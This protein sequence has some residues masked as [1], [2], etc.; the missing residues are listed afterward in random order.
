MSYNF[1]NAQRAKLVPFP[2]PSTDPSKTELRAAPESVPLVTEHQGMDVLSTEECIELLRQEELGRIGFVQRG[3]PVILPVNFVYAAH[4]ILFR[5]APGSK[6][7]VAQA[8]GRVAFEVDDWSSEHRTGGSVVAK[9]T[10]Q[11]MT[12]EWFVA[13]AEVLDVEPWAD[14]I[15]R[16]HWV[17][18]EIAEITGRWIFRNPKGSGVAVVGETNGR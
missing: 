12:D 5:T 18:I 13:I 6:L 11:E 4:S 2:R 1:L 14:Q 9:G 15:P 7:E 17:R 3:Q 10:A 16:D 8:G